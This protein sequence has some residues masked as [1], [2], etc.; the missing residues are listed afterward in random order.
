MFGIRVVVFEGRSIRDGHYNKGGINQVYPR[1]SDSTLR[2][3]QYLRP[4]GGTIRKGRSI[5]RLIPNLK[6]LQK[7]IV[8]F[9]GRFIQDGRIIRE[10]TLVQGFK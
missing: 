10:N 8:L 6:V 5:Y 3:L 7:W 1:N 2:R 9:E 4:F